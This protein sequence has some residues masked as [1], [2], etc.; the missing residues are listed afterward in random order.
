MAL[1]KTAA[2][3]APLPAPERGVFAARTMGNVDVRIPMERSWQ[4]LRAA[5]DYASIYV[6]TYAW[7][8]AGC[9]LARQR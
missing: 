1:T 2:Q 8:R 7:R 9:F 3:M 6:C 5:L 4:V